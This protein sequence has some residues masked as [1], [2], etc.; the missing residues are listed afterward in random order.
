MG[1]SRTVSEI[2]GDFRQKTQ[3]TPIFKVPLRALPFEFCKDVWAVGA[4]REKIDCI[5]TVSTNQHWTDEGQ[6]G[7]PYMQ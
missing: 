6:T 1:L 3:N 5:T 2:H 7:R 4:V